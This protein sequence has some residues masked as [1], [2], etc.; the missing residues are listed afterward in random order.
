MSK[1]KV[2]CPKCKT[3]QFVYKDDATSRKLCI[4][5]GGL[6]IAAELLKSFR[7]TAIFSVSSQTAILAQVV[8]YDFLLSR[9]EKRLERQSRKGY[10]GHY[11]CR[12]CNIKFR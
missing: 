2:I 4:I 5:A 8:K 3:E 10:I 9:F 1:Q 7:Y 12:K 11:C 6:G